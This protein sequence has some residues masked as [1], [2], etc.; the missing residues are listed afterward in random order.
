MFETGRLSKALHLN[1]K[2]VFRIRMSMK[3]LS[4]INRVLAVLCLVLTVAVLSPFTAQA[5]E[6][7]QYVTVEMKADT[8]A[9]RP[10]KAFL[11][12]FRQQ[13]YPD[14]HT[15]WK[16]PGDTGAETR[17]ALAMPEGFTAGEILWP[18]PERV[19]YEDMFVNFGYAGE[20][21]FLMEVMPPAE[22]SATEVT[23][24]ADKSWLVCK[25]ICIPE[26]GK[27]SITL[28]VK[29]EAAP[30]NTEFFAAAKAQQPVAVDWVAEFSKTGDDFVLALAHDGSL[31]AD[32][33]I[34]FFPAAWGLID[35]LAEQQ[36]DF[37][38]HKLTVRVKAGT[39]DFAEVPETMSVLRIDDGQGG[40]KAYR[41][42]AK[43]N[44][45]AGLAITPAP[46]AGGADG[47]VSFRFLTH[48]ALA[49][50]G[51]MILNLMPCVF[52]VLS[53]KALSLVKH[54]DHGRGKAAMQ[55][56]SY[57]LGVVASFG[58]VAGG[59]MIFQSF[60]AAVGWGFQ[61]QNPYVILGLAALMFLIGL[62]LAG[63]FEVTLN[64]GGAGASLTRGEG[65]GASF[66]TG[67][68]ATILATPC[69]APFM[70]AAIGYALTQP[71]AQ[72]M[73]I[74]LVMGLGLAL[75]YLALTLFPSLR[76][77]LPRPGAWME[78]FRQF[79][80]FPM[81]LTAAW[82]VWVLGQQAGMDAVFLALAAFT[83]LAW[84]IWL[85]D[86]Q[87]KIWARGFA[88]VIAAALL[89]GVYKLPTAPL[90]P[91]PGEVAYTP[92]GLDGLLAADDPVLVNMTA[93]WCITCKVNERA[94]LKTDAA[95]ALFETRRV[96]LVTGDWTRYDEAIT[97]YLKQFDRR[98]VPLYVYY[99]PRDPDS[100]ARPAPVVLP[101][102][103]TPQI[104]REAL[105]TD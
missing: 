84:I 71:V 85:K 67:V 32:G 35:N 15:Y 59:L 63:F 89:Y 65:Y 57:T 80:A 10:G 56:V 99:G 54:G 75:P 30:D 48:L 29:T 51:G 42:T 78:R 70:A 94:V 14:W 11:L 33:K 66:F 27:Y 58:L 22:I 91:A 100:G 24:T 36:A 8:D 6:P 64:L 97:A 26:E 69:T 16:N 52:P 87:K 5:G 96:T 19:A 40:V 38:D 95:H 4:F 3:Q 2:K 98:G 101:Q 90:P 9:V 79:L 13:I 68:L 104:L 17:I 31:T 73:G 50:L 1:E 83:G 76:A 82:L 46:D 47:F 20:A 37:Q 23:I 103:L 72:A 74:F 44:T 88:L 60:G 55:G 21:Y 105:G 18:V 93:A 39:R 43:K 86:S 28:P 34:S 41:F 62:N 61:L 92:A 53:L 49:L 81:F 12:G 45:D 25:E 77:A 7:A 102:I